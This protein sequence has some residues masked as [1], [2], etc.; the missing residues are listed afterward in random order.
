MAKRGNGEGSIFRSSSGKW[1]ATISIPAEHGT[2]RRMKRECRSRADAV[3]ALAAMKAMVETSRAMKT[4]VTVSAWC[5]SWLAAN[6]QRWS[7]NTTSQ[8]ECCVRNWIQPRIGAVQLAKLTSP[9]VVQLLADCRAAGAKSRT[10]A[11][12]RSVLVGAINAAVKQDLLTENVA[13]RVPAP[14]SDEKQID[15]FLEDEVRL[16]LQHTTG[17][18][19]HALYTLAFTTGLRIG[20]L[21]GLKRRNLDLEHRTLRIDDQVTDVRGTLERRK[22]KT[23]SSRRTIELSDAAVSALIAHQAIMLREGNAGNELLFP[24]R[25]GRPHRRTNFVRRHW[26]P[27]LEKLGLQHRGIHHTR[28]TFATQAM[29]HGVPLTVVSAVLGHSR[30]EITMRTYSHFLRGD[31][32]LAVTAMD[33]L[34]SGGYAVAPVVVSKSS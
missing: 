22:T 12:I 19:N 16:I 23:K 29:R 26:G 30:P 17:T 1:V 21:L 2:R 13:A 14:R 32:R 24:G 10:L 33:S 34:V 3:A 5:V 15:P 20:E 28:H 7:S 4:K 6:E 31:Q 27:L 11:V 8:R 9:Q 18:R 25:Q